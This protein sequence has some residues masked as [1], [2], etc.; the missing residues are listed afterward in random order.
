MKLFVYGRGREP[1][2]DP[3]YAGQLFLSS[4]EG[5]QHM[6]TI[7]IALGTKVSHSHF[8]CPLEFCIVA[9][10]DMVDDYLQMAVR[11]TIAAAEDFGLRLETESIAPIKWASL[12]P[13]LVRN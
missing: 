10:V 3:Y 13:V 7:D 12:A 11:R 8:A 1:W 2:R 6:K 9:I 5:V 4:A